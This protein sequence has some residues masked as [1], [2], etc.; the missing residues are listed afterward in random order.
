MSGSHIDLII[1]AMSAVSLVIVLLC[2]IITIHYHITSTHLKITWL[3][4]PVRWLRLDDIKYVSTKRCFWAERWYN[5]LFVSNRLLVIHRRKGLYKAFIIT[6]KNPFVFKAEL[7]QARKAVVPAMSRSTSLSQDD[8][9]QL[10]HKLGGSH[11]P[12]PEAQ[13]EPITNGTGDAAG[14][15]ADSGKL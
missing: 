11:T 6:P 15:T 1:A 10:F 13:K 2:S 9:V 5:T 3:G 12:P 14:S 7:Y 8:T 4:I